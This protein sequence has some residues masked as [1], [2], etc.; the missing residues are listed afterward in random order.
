MLGYHR[1]FVLFPF[2]ETTFKFHYRVATLR[3]K[4][5]SFDCQVAYAG[6]TV[7]D[8][9][10]VVTEPFQ[11]IPFI[12]GQVDTAWDVTCNEIFRKANVNDINVLA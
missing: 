8:V 6:I 10:P 3:K 7:Y 2:V 9:I 12:L 5:A 11:R 4:Q 1:Q